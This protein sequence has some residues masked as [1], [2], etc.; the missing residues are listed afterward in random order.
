MGRLYD[1]ALVERAAV[2]TAIKLAGKTVLPI[3]AQSWTAAEFAAR[4]RRNGLIVQIGH[5]LL[6]G[7]MLIALAVD[8]GEESRRILAWAAPVVLASAIALYFAMRPRASAPLYRDPRIAVAVGA[9]GIV[10]HGAGSEFR[11]SWGEIEAAVIRTVDRQGIH[12]HGVRFESPL[13]PI[14]LRGEA[15]REGRRAAAAIVRGVAAHHA[16]RERR[17]VERIG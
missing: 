1:D 5:A 10:V 13:G 15:Y 11:Q 14:A 17:K 2:K 3:H 16:E 8:G 7:G 6:M 4:A 9:G 12:F